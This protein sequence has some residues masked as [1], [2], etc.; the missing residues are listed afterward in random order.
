M[1]G[2]S[3]KGCRRSAVDVWIDSTTHSK[4]GIKAMTEQATNQS[5]MLVEDDA[6]LIWDEAEL[7]VFANVVTTY[8]D[9]V[10]VFLTFGC[11]DAPLNAPPSSGD[12]G[13]VHRESIK[14]I[15][16]V[17]LAI[18]LAE[19]RRIANGFQG[20]LKKIDDLLVKFPRP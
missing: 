6:K 15:P 13:I 7:P 11:T 9:G 1:D 8:C 16:V 4:S 10:T 2:R 18:P 19:F 14:A 3:H 12:D 5:P 20:T 17:R